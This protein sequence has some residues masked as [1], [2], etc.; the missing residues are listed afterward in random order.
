MGAQ[1]PVNLSDMNIDFHQIELEEGSRDVTTISAGDSL[2]RYKRLR[3]D[4][5]SAPEQ[6]ENI[7]NQTIAGYPEVT[8]IV[9]GMVT[10]ISYLR[11]LLKLSKDT[12]KRSKAENKGHLFH[13][14]FQ[15]VALKFGSKFGHKL[16]QNY[17]S[18]AGSNLLVKA[19]K[20]G[21][22]GLI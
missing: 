4:K 8:N 16:I 5:N 11:S 3:F 7:I 13:L 15:F 21:R 12:S 2:F 10:S 19:G 20:L 17:N 1:S 9:D 18:F 14:S 22:K 6:F